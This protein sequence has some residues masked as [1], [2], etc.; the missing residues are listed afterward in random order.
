MLK[1]QSRVLN[2]SDLVFKMPRVY[3]LIVFNLMKLDDRIFIVLYMYY[4][5]K[6]KFTTDMKVHKTVTITH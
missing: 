6:D 1:T 2:S 3:F 4:T 5:V